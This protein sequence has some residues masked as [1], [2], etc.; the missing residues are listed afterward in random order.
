MSRGQHEGNGSLHRRCRELPEGFVDDIWPL[1]CSRGQQLTE[2]RGKALQNNA[3][4]C[5]MERD[6][7]QPL[8]KVQGAAGRCH[9]VFETSTA[10]G[11]HKHAILF[12]GRCRVDGRWWEDDS[13]GF[14]RRIGPV[15]K[16]EW[17]REG[18]TSWSFTCVRSDGWRQRRERGEKDLWCHKRKQGVY[19]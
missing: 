3:C 4:S 10:R 12:G 7:R 5:W 19:I 8:P 15:V 17:P 16:E 6:E 14:G 18:S 11:G 9:D 13:G 2:L 1:R